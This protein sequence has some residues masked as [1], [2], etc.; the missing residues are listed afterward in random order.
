[1]PVR[2]RNRSCDHAHQVLRR[3][4]R[5]PGARSNDGTGNAAREALFPILINEVRQLILRKAVNQISGSFA[6]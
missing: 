6:R 4:E 1:M 3:S 2:G 5:M